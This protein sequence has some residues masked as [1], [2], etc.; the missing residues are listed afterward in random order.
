MIKKLF[1]TALLAGAFVP[2]MACT[3]NSGAYPGAP[4][5]SCPTISNVNVTAD[6][7]TGEHFY[8]FTAHCGV[9][10]DYKVNGNWYPGS[11]NLAQEFITEVGG[12][13]LSGGTAS[14]CP[15]LDPWV[16]AG[17]LCLFSGDWGDVPPAIS[18]LPS[19]G[20]PASAF[21]LNAAERAQLKSALDAAL[22]PKATPTPNP[23]IIVLP[24]GLLPPACPA[25]SLNAQLAQP[26]A[27]GTYATTVP[28]KVTLAANPCNAALKFDLEWQWSGQPGVDQPVLAMLDETANPNGTSVQH[29]AFGGHSGG[30]QVRAKVHGQVNAPWSSW[31]TFQVL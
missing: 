31:D 26:M 3:L 20:F 21:L 15:P 30:W 12:Q 9:D 18:S 4:G 27:N 2:A 24:G 8:N 11:T 6:T 13:Q 23:G 10:G 7:N 22:K 17:S 5:V 14:Q 1:G 29:A 19:Y 28:I 25:S 16:N